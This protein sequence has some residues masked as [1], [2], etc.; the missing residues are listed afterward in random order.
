VSQA[1][2]VSTVSDACLRWRHG[3]KVPDPAF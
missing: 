2:A 1:L 3:G